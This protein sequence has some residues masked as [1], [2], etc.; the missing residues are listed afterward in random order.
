MARRIY[1]Q[2]VLKWAKLIGI[3][4]GSIIFLIFGYL[5]MTGCIEINS[6]SG[7]MTCAGTIDDPCYAYVT[8]TAKEDVFIYPTGYDPYGRSVGFDFDPAPKE[9]VLQRSWGNGWRTI[10]L[11]KPWSS[12][13]KYAIK[14]GKGT[15]YDLRII[16]YK[17]SP[18]DVI[19]WGFGSDEFGVNTYIDP[20]W[21]SIGGANNI[22]INS[23]SQYK[24]II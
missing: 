11:S 13:V 1:T 18:S 12:K 7:D 10:N 16:G 9:A 19:K 4:S 22:I 21:L 14:F 6:I 2:T 23:S 24:W 3:S 15:T 8:F 5:T 17:N 20:Y